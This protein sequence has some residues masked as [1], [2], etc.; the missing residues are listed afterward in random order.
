MLWWHQPDATGFVERFRGETMAGESERSVVEGS[1]ASLPRGLVLFLILILIS[2]VGIK[3][4]IT[5][6]IKMRNGYA[7]KNRQACPIEGS[8]ELNPDHFW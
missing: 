2:G 5:I 6:K 7:E 4:R 3:I 1:P 8:R